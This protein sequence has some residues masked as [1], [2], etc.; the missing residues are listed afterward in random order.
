MERAGKLVDVGSGAG[1][2]GIPL[3]IA[4][5]NLRVMLVESTRKKV[6]FCQ[7]VIDG[8]GLEGIQA[9]HIRAEELGHEPGQ[10]GAYDWAVGRAVAS[11]RVLGEY[12]LPFLRVGGRMIAM[13]GET[14]P[15]EA[16]EAEGALRLLGGQIERLLP[17]ELPTV[18]ETRYLILVDKVSATPSEYPRRPGVPSKRPLEE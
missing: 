1:F 2:P 18:A 11:L 4:C 6:E 10:R 5:P 17:I 9:S 8:L 12:L 3:K 14:G 13:K 16:H 15:A 7:H